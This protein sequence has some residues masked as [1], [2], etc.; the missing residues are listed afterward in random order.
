MVS[1]HE[2]KFPSL[3]PRKTASLA[4]RSTRTKKKKILFKRG[5]N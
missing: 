5:K 2:T 4:A 1:F 3:S